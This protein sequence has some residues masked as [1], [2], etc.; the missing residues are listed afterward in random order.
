M[1][2]GEGT[3]RGQ[4]VKAIIELHRGEMAGVKLKPFCLGQF[5]RIEPVSPVIV[6][7]AGCANKVLRQLEPPP[8]LILASA[9]CY[10]K[11]YFEIVKF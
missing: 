7:P 3:L 11:L 8:A 1:P 6:V 2:V 9:G 10:S 5:L 4:P